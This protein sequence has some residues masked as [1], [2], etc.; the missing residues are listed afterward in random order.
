MGQQIAG[1]ARTHIEHGRQQQQRQP[2]A[3][4][5]LEELN[6]FPQSFDAIE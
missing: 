3:V 2:N 6:R 4:I 5:V 1:Q